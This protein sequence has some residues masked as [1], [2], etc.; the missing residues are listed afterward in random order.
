VE[1]GRPGARGAVHGRRSLG[2]TLTAGIDLGS[3]AVKGVLFDPERGVL[4]TSEL[5][6]DLYSLAP[7]TAEADPA[8]WWTATCGVT[9]RLLAGAGATGTDVGAISVSGMVPALVSLDA[10][11]QP[12]RRA[13]L[14]N[15]ARATV[16]VHEL[17]EALAGDDLLA[18]TGS[19]VSQQSVAPTLLWLSRHE[20]DVVQQTRYVVGSYDWLLHRLGAVLHVERNWALESGLFTLGG[21]ALDEVF[22][23]AGAEPSLVPPV[24]EPGDVVG[25]LSTAAA[26]ELGLAE[27][28]PLVVATADHVASAY[29][30]GLAAEPEALLKL[31]GA[32]DILVVSSA[33][34]VDERLYLD[35]HMIPGLWLPN[36]CMAT[37]GTLLRWFQEVLAN[38]AEGLVCLPYLLGEKSPLHDPNLR[39]A[40]L[41]LHLGH[42]RQ[43][44][45]RA[46]LEAVA[47]GFRQHL[48]V[49]AQL[50]MTVTEARV[51]NGG[52]ASGLWKRIL[53]DVC[54]IPLYPVLAHPGAALGAALAAAVGI[55]LLPAWEAVQGYVQL[56]P[57]MTPDSSTAEIYDRQ[58][59]T[60]MLAGKA[61]EEISHRIA[62]SQSAD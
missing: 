7:A 12:L 49:Y 40:F 22:R 30:A 33:A 27:G 61:V 53:A 48:E 17:R 18:R 24:S 58:Y 6:V 46:C 60:Y 52:A 51:T 62:I 59:E 57:E 31:G 21:D 9:G 26:K 28:T 5:P 4:A 8:D 45:F 54:G 14:Q 23:R 13:I 47:F 35:R 29:A 42:R 25:H 15:D 2:V 20:P 36:G 38:G 37:S 16:E 50:G 55:G 10:R 32:G 11:G 34:R 39:G 41:G 44:L 3:S 43:H 56:G 19:V 1:P